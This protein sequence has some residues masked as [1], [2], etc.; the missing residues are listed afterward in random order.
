MRLCSWCLLLSVRAFVR[1]NAFCVLVERTPPNLH[2]SV[3][4]NNMVPSCWNLFS[5]KVY[6]LFYQIENLTTKGNSHRGLTCQVSHRQSYFKVI[7]RSTKWDNNLAQKQNK[8]EECTIQQKR[9]L[10]RDKAEAIRVSMSDITR[11]KYA[12]GKRHY[13]ASYSRR[14]T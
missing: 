8:F 9:W 3:Q 1:S 12:L 13:Q 6:S 11:K 4:K 2:T 10:A 5:P 14:A 7:L